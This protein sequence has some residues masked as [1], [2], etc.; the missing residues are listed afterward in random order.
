MRITALGETRD[1]PGGLTLQ[2]EIGLLPHGGACRHQGVFPAFAGAKAAAV[3]GGGCEVGGMDHADHRPGGDPGLARGAHPP[4]GEVS[5]V[6]A[7]GDP[8][9][10]GLQR[11]GGGF[12]QVPY[13]RRGTAGPADA[14]G[15]PAA[16]PDGDGSVL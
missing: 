4:A 14:L 2:D 7:D 3:P 5:G 13:R 12:G 10:E 1:W 8:G 16:G 6:G 15:G 11:R 9:V